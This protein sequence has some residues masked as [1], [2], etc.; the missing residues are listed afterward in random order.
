[1]PYQGEY[2][3][4]DSTWELYTLNSSTG[5]YYTVGFVP[6]VF[7]L[8]TITFVSCGYIMIPICLPYMLRYLCPVDM[9]KQKT[10]ETTFFRWNRHATVANSQ[11]MGGQMELC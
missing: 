11:W 8:L 1:M 7:I 2:Y 10:I 3:C 5:S 6:F 4:H 9:D